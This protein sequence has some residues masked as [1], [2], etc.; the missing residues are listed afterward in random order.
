MIPIIGKKLE[1]LMYIKI[2]NA[3]VAIED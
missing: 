3:S 1:F 2:Q